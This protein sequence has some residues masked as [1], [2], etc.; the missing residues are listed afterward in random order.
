MRHVFKMCVRI[1]VTKYDFIVSETLPV[2]WA[3]I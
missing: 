3:E 2:A 1:L